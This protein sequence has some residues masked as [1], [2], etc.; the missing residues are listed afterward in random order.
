L[1]NGLPMGGV[2][3]IDVAYLSAIATLVSEGIGEG[4]TG[5]VTDMLPSPISLGSPR[6]ESH[7]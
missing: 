6:I 2:V 3:T 7:F 1:K 5:R 4:E